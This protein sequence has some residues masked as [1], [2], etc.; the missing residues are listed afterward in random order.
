M[1]KAI[2]PGSFDPI[3]NGHLNIINRAT[4]IFDEI[5]VAIGDNASKNGLFTLQERKRMIEA[6]LSDYSNVTVKI[7]SN[8]TV[9]FLKQEHANILIRGIR[10]TKDFENEQEI[11]SLNQMLDPQI[12]TVLLFANHDYELISSSM[13]KEI[14][15]FGGDTSKFV[16]RVVSK[17]LKEKQ[18]Q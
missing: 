12:E 1:K 5:V 7:Y 4:Q 14:N 8:L 11:A 16:P 6:C 2:Y 3:T 17:A 13:V 18:N 15:H 10:D 9:D